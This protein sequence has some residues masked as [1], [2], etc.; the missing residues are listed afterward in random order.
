M[1]IYHNNRCSKSRLAIKIL[2]SKIS[3]LEIVDY[4]KNPIT[5]EEL[6]TIIHKLKIE[7]IQLIR[8]NEAL[9]KEKY[10]KEI[11]ENDQLIRI[12]IANPKLMQRPI[13]INNKTGII[14]R[15]KKDILTFID[16]EGISSSSSFPSLNQTN[17]K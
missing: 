12:M 5:F 1:K 6:K 3:N 11:I 16:Q 15:D 8:K 17:M 9:W 7:P 14:A 4:I 10:K 2:S 13:V